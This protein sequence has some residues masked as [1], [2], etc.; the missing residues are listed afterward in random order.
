MKS[1]L[2]EVA[3]DLYDKFQGDFTNVAVVFP[4]KRA[5]LFFN[6]HLLSMTEQPIWSPTYIS[7]QELFEQSSS[8]KLVDP[9][10]AVCLLYQSFVKATGSKESLDDFYFWGELLLN[11]FD[12][13]D[14]NLVD[15][16][17]LFK[18][19]AE[20]HA[21]SDTFDFLEEGQREA[22]QMFFRNLSLS[23]ETELKRRFIH[24]WDK[25]GEI[26]TDFR[27]RLLQ[28]K[29][30]YEG[31][32]YRFV[33]DSLDLDSLPY[34]HYVFVGFNVL[35]KVEK[36][37]FRTLDRAKRA[38]FYW[39]YDV[40][41][42]DKAEHEAGVF[43]RQNLEEFPSELPRKCFDNF[44]SPKEITFIG[45][46]TDN[47][48]ARY[49][50]KWIE[51]NL[52]K[53][54]KETAVVLCNEN[55]LQ[56]TLH[57]LP[58]CVQQTNVTMGFPMQQTP[59]FTFVTALLSLYTDGWI[60][61]LQRFSYRQVGTV[62]RHPYTN[63]I[64]RQS[65]EIDKGL[66]KGNRLYPSQEEL[67]LD[68][69]LTL[70]FSPVSEG[71][72]MCTVIRD[73]LKQVALTCKVKEADGINSFE[74]LYQE[75]LFKAY[76]LFNRFIDLQSTGILSVS[77]TMLMRLIK[78]AFSV[79]SIPFHGEP[80]VGLQVMGVLETRNLDFKHLIL[81][82]VDE[83]NLPKS[84]V[85]SSFIPYHLRKAF[86]MTT[87]DHKVSVYAY[88]FYR[89]IQRADRITMLYNSNAEGLKKGEKSR[90]ML[91]L[92]VESPHTIKQLQLAPRQ[93]PLQHSVEEIVKTPAM[94]EELIEKYRFKKDVPDEKIKLLSPSA[95][96][97]YITCPAQF[98]YEYVA[99]L[100]VENEMAEDIDA[101]LFGTIFHKVAEDIYTNAPRKLITKEYIEGLL[102]NEWQIERL[103]D[104]AFR[105]EFFKEQNPET[106]LKYNGF[107][108][109]N[110]EVVLRYIKKLL[111]IDRQYTPFT[112]ESAEKRIYESFPV[113]YN[114]KE[115]IINIG[116][117]VDRMDLKDGVLRIVDYKTGKEEGAI[118]DIEDVYLNNVDTRKKNTFQVF[119]YSSIMA[120]KLREQGKDYKISPSLL[121]IS[122][123]KEK[124]P[125]LS[126]VLQNESITDFAQTLVVSEDQKP[127]LLENWMRERLRQIIDELMN[128][129]VPFHRRASKNCDYCPFAKRCNI[130][131][132]DIV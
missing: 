85:E 49:L 78:M 58:A 8:L 42:I 90:F 132:S 6:E 5:S 107:Q 7:I 88:Y 93:N 44:S 39:D 24:L 65:I 18:N 125:A 102:K 70:I 63:L 41:Y 9:I 130:S 113:S 29:W 37:L 126:V 128:V 62:L 100:R 26:Y 86:G 127:H 83:G 109:L 51:E 81:L 110:R 129:D 22:L 45:S 35:N 1:F 33:V 59:V 76:T 80:A 12:D 99:G 101:A 40:F 98:Y 74:P 46:A 84:G 69:T 38:L 32:L 112:F 106:K 21:I 16:N 73:L 123:I 50:T 53:E 72:S 120:R 48:E 79:V 52:T 60:E 105:T 75:T 89:L 131:K 15:A 4:N 14:K 122:S 64:S 28:E 114:G 57:T 27:N 95:L 115:A 103:V 118:K 56:P 54:E 34:Q 124:E 20:L 36:K 10:T 91:Q 87:I 2:K 68:E 116:G 43:M 94:I 97:K 77:K 96:N 11:D 19:L 111:R 104:E 47:A 31:M 82:S 3:Q 117:V 30:A 121:Y 13:V 67:H 119:L 71:I 55:L 61:N 66:R 92:L 23:E 17:D 25:L 108:L